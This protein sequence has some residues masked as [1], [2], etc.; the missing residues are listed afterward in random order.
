MTPAEAARRE[1]AR[2]AARAR[3]AEKAIRCGRTNKLRDIHREVPRPFSVV[4]ALYSDRHPEDAMTAENIRYH[5]KRAEAKIAAALLEGIE[6]CGR[7]RAKR[8]SPE[9]PPDLGD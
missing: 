6:I 5:V 1:R 9:C 4:A 2:A 3:I 7:E 8:G